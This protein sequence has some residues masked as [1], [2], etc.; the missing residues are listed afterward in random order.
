MQ[1]DKDAIKNARDAALRAMN[2]IR[3]YKMGRPIAPV[4]P[5]CPGCNKICS[6]DQLFTTAQTGMCKK[7]SDGK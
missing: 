1:I 6:S 5:I 2:A 4:W 7:C 3:F